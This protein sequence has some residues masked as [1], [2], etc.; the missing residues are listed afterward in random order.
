MTL[1]PSA[2]RFPRAL[3][4]ASLI[5]LA[6]FN[7]HASDEQPGKGIR[8]QPLQ[9]PIA[10]ETFQTLLVMKALRASMARSMSASDG[11]GTSDSTWP[12]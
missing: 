6:A 4:C 11:G 7:A 9:S 8:I 5:G 3:L 1:L 10:E 2:L 12:R